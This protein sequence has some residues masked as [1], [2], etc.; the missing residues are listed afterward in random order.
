MITNEKTIKDI[1]KL[2]MLKKDKYIKE[3]GGNCKA[4]HW[5]VIGVPL[6]KN[7]RKKFEKR[8]KKQ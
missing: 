5:K 2:C 7:D 1:K 6:N 8:Y 3:I 4:R